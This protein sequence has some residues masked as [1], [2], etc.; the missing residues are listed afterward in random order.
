ME[1]TTLMY[2]ILIVILIIIFIIFSKYNKMIKLI[3]RVK[4]AKA[5][6]EIVLNKR[7]DLIPNLVEC[8]KSYS[9]H[10][11]TTLE[12]VVALRS[13]YNDE[14]NKSIKD[15]EKLNNDLTKYLITIENYPE[16]KANENFLSLQ[17]ELRSIEDELSRVRNIYNDEVTRYNTLIE[18]VPTNII[19]SIF[20]FKKAR[21]FQIE[22]EKKENTKLN[23]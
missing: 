18:S 16:L 17:N 1:I 21:W 3:N 10:E 12:E 4:R 11:S 15:V 19:A 2:I 23:L 22:E 9:K 13:K 5:N 6:I 7:F 8:V 14:K 20:G